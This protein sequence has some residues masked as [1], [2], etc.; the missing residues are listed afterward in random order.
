M[1]GPN[2]NINIFEDG[3]ANLETLPCFILRIV[4]QKLQSKDILSEAAWLPMSQPETNQ[5]LTESAFWLKFEIHNASGRALD[6]YITIGNE[7]PY[8]I[9][10]W[11]RSNDKTLQHYQGGSKVGFDSR[12]LKTSLEGIPTRLTPNETLA[13]YVRVANLRT[14]D[15]TVRL[16]EF[17]SLMKFERRRT[18]EAGIFIGAMA[19]IIIYNL[20]LGFRQSSL[21]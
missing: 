18:L 6:R 11:L 14:T 3:V 2:D 7:V 15:L 1:Q 13:V 4:S 16:L 17:D 10:F 5:G 8:D 21:F 20:F 19:L 9:E 12:I